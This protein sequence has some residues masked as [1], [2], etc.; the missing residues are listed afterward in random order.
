MQDPNKGIAIYRQV[1]EQD[2]Y[3]VAAHLSLADLYMR[4]AAAGPLAIQEHLHVVRLDPAKV[5]SLHALFRLWDGLRQADKA[6]CAAG[7]LHFLKATNDVE[8]SSYNDA[9]NRLPPERPDGLQQADV[10]LLMHPAARTA[11]TEVLRAVGDQVSRLY[12][13]NLEALGIDRKQDRLKPDNAV[14]KAIRSVAQ[15]FGVEDFEVYTAHR[16]VVTLETGEPLAVCVG[17]DVVRRFN[18]R[19]QK[20]LFGRAAMGLVNRS[21]LVSKL[22]SGEL[23]DLLGN[24]IRIHQPGFN[25]LGRRNDETVK[26]LRKTLSRK[27]LKALEVPAAS[28]AGTPALD[29]KDFAQA[30][31]YSGDRAGLLLCGD[32]TVGLQ[33]VLRDDPNFATAK[34]EATEPLL[35]A[36]RQRDDL[37]AMINFVLSEECFKLRAKLGVALP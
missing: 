6:F 8:I 7:V 2:P 13:P 37:R 1:V 10:D 36:V 31:Q 17:S 11:L 19:E 21:A 12:P 29:L 25:G 9:R 16:G 3:N 14:F 34:P 15:L 35:Q 33:M 24:A 5:D 20:F 28:L 18:A 32:V 30:L 26:N 4:D 22:S 27:A 23:A